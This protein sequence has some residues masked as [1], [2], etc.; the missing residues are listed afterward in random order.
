MTAYKVIGSA[1]RRLV[2]LAIGFSM[3][4]V[5]W[6]AGRALNN[7]RLHVGAYRHVPI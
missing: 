6:G 5:S 7:S 3:S 4:P 2:M 1:L